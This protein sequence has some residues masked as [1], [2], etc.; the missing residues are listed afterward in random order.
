MHIIVWCLSLRLN[1]CG[2]S[3]LPIENKKNTQ[4]KPL[5]LTGMNFHSWNLHIVIVRTIIIIIVGIS[6]I[7]FY[8]WMCSFVE[9]WKG[10]M[11]V[12]CY[13]PTLESVCSILF[14]VYMSWKGDTKGS[15]SQFSIMILDW[16]DRQYLNDIVLHPS[17]LYIWGYS[18]AT[19]MKLHGVFYR[20]K[21]CV[22]V[23]KCSIQT[24][25]KWVIL[26]WMLNFSAV[27]FMSVNRVFWG[28]KSPLPPEVLL[29]T[30]SG[31]LSIAVS[32]PCIGWW[33]AVTETKP[34]GSLCCCCLHVLLC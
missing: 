5:L 31:C 9:H 22:V 10:E 27:P 2:S 8:Y 14:R 32:W 6:F 26:I 1:V 25:W 21:I 19:V 3:S 34:I 16:P 12:G 24:K 30:L 7:I 28:L 17:S 23:F 11:I 15:D 29:F 18:K 13:P 4:N 20:S 33:G